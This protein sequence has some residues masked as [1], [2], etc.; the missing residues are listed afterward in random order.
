MD[1]SQFMAVLSTIAICSLYSKRRK[2]TILILFYVVQ[3]QTWRSPSFCSSVYLSPNRV[4]M[5]NRFAS[6]GWRRRNPLDYFC[7]I[8]YLL[9]EIQH[10]Q[11]CSVSLYVLSLFPFS[12]SPPLNGRE[13][14]LSAKRKVRVRKMY[15]NTNRY[16]DETKG[17]DKEMEREDT[18]LRDIEPWCCSINLQ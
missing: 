9:R 16:K 10:F 17:R 5:K 3:Y 6:L 18:S 11:S 7:L 8:H 14:W 1:I 15:F 2:Q 4:I 13:E 12:K